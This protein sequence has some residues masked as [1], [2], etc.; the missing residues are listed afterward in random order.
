MT[1]LEVEDIKGFQTITKQ[2]MVDLDAGRKTVITYDTVEY[3]LGLPE[4]IFTERYLRRAPRK[5]L[6]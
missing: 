5:Y 1:V 6:R 2:Q 4:D 3:N